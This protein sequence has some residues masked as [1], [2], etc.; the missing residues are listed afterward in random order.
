MHYTDRSRTGVNSAAQ[1]TDIINVIQVCACV[2]RDRE[3]ESFIER[4][5]DI[6][7]ER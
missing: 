2:Y 4:D 3:T 7:R 5:R 1:R 6:Y